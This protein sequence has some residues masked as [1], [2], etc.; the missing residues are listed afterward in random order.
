MEKHTRIV[1]WSSVFRRTVSPIAV[2]VSRSA[3]GS[4]MQ[5]CAT[6]SNAACAKP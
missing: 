2:S 3:A 4:G 5:L 6:A 1:Y